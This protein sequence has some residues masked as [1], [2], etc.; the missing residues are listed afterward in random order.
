M[1]RRV[2]LRPFNAGRPGRCLWCDKKLTKAQKDDSAFCRPSCG[3]Q[4][5]ERLATIG[6][7]LTDDGWKML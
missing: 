5:G 6:V 4:F 2:K 7:Q 1:G 3:Y